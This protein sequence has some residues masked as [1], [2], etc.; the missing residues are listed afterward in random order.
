MGELRIMKPIV[1]K[2]PMQWLGVYFDFFLSF[3]NHIEKVAGKRYKAA[4]S[5]SMLVKITRRIKTLIMQKLVYTYI[6]LIFI[7]KTLA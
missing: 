1:K 3:S 6:L 5:L 7:Y 4:S 2:A